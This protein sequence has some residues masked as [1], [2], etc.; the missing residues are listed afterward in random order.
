M[1]IGLDVGGTHTDVVLIGDEGLQRQIKVPTDTS[2]LFETV[3]AGLEK[4]T[5]GISI[6]QITHAVLSTTL[7][8]NA[9][10]QGKLSPAGMIVTS[11]PGIDPEL[12]RTGPH[13]HVVP[14]A[15]DHSGRE[16]KKIDRDRV[17]AAA[18]KMAAD[19]I[20]QVGVVGK[21]SSRNPAHEREIA[22]LLRNR[23]ERVFMGHRISG[24]FGFPRRINTTF[25]NASVYPV[26]RTFFEAVKKSLEKK[27]I[28]IPIHV[29]KADGGTM[30]LETSIDFPGQTILS[31]P[32]AS[33]MGSVAFAADNIETLVLD[34]GG[35]STDMAVLING[36]PLLSPHGVDLGGYKTLIR[37][38]NTQ[39]IGI[40]GDSCVRV[41]NG[42]IRIGPDRCGAAMGYGGPAPTPT[43]ALFVLDRSQGGDKAL[44]MQ[45][46]EPIA[47]EL[48]LSVEEAAYEIF[49]T[50]CREILAGAGQMIAEI[51]SKPVYTVRE[52]LQ[53][54]QVSPHHILVLGGPAPYFAEHFENTS[55]YTV[56]TIPECQVA[57]AIGTAL[58]RTTCEVTLFV[59]T[60]K[61]LATAPEESFSQ[62]V[63]SGFSRGDAHRMVDELL[64]QKA[65]RLGANVQDIEAE[66]LE[67]LEFN[68]VRGF[69]MMGKNLRVKQQIK[70]GLIHEFQAI[71]R[72]IAAT[73]TSSSL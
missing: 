58:S 36:V 52:A 10:V 45:G 22:E 26:H 25:L 27:G 14:G 68:I 2:A 18:D 5:E 54:Y 32:A 71:S 53:R 50:T 41:Q 51:N 11:G 23:F 46:L 59:D 3:L 33:I 35:T 56:E 16:I 72:K 29:L 40:G 65:V 73:C 4:I 9:I 24:N 67:D 17:A 55:G 44:A 38:L 39:S 69:R 15:I 48:G 64:R 57:N 43:D 19:G 70:P 63:N 12:F 6:D 60:Q 34:I 7:T 13:Y 1:I 66:I 31:G 42:K 62:T 30:G 47:R 20:E 21:F 37:A 28:S 8:T 49:D 61:G